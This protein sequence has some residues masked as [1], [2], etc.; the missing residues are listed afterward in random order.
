M[1][2]TNTTTIAERLALP[3]KNQVI[4]MARR[5][6]LGDKPAAPVKVVVKTEAE[7]ADEREKRRLRG[8]DYKRRLRE[9]IAA[10]PEDQ[11]P[12]R[13]AAPKPKPAQRAAPKR[14]QGLDLDASE[15]P[16]VEVLADETYGPSFPNERLGQFRPKPEIMMGTRTFETLDS[17]CGCKWPV[18]DPSKD[19][20]RFCGRTKPND[21]D[22]PYCAD[23][24][25]AAYMALPPK[26]GKPFKLFIGAK[27]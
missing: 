11:R 24:A 10:L 12:K 14:T 4:G 19:W 9:R 21:P 16:H 23:H 20:F 2:E 5:M 26:G 13:K 17:R 27:R 15:V 7:L 22:I 6:E 18:G 8:I 1:P 25:Q 3:G